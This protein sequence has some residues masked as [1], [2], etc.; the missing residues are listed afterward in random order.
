LISG[1]KSLETDSFRIESFDIAH[2]GGKDMVG[3]MVVS[4]SGSLEKSEY[5]KFN[6]YGITSSNDTGA[7]RQVLE[8]R[9][10]HKEWTTPNLVVVDGGDLQLNTALRVLRSLNLNIDVV[11]VVKDDKHKPKAILGKE[12]L[13]KKYKKDILLINAEAHRFAIAF[14]K[15]KRRKSFIIGE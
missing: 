14:H 12:S 9:F 15:K 10:A 4:N 3:V 11:S 7:L 13:V 8:R 1:E 5:K 6:V 2:F